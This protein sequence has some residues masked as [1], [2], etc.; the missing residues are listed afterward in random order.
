MNAFFLYITCSKC[1]EKIKIRINPDTDINDYTLKKEVLG[2]NCQNL[3]YLNL[4]FDNSY[5]ITAENITGGSLI[6]EKEFLA[7]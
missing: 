3:I 1:G 2:N 4:Q 5:N 6:T 7:K